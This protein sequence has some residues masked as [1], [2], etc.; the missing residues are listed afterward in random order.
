[1]SEALIG[2]L[3]AVIGVVVGALG[4]YFTLRFNYKSLYAQVVSQSRNNWLNEMRK[5]ISQ[6]LAAKKSELEYIVNQSANNNPSIIQD[7]RERYYNA[8]A[9][10]LIR[11]NKNE[12]LPKKLE[13][14]I[15]KIDKL[16]KKAKPGNQ[17]VISDFEN[18]EKRIIDYCREYFKKEWERV[19]Q[20]ASGDDYD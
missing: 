7:C 19:K 9:E 3:S 20:E 15:K 4:T 5:Y 1:M 12:D 16:V 18:K 11:L 8:K 6:M 10:V 13:K 14:E 2:L 17:T